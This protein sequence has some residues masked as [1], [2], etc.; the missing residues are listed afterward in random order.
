MMRTLTR[1]P[2]FRCAAVALA[3]AALLYLGV[4]RLLL[5]MRRFGCCPIYS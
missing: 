3:A 2:V 5:S 4:L 1:S